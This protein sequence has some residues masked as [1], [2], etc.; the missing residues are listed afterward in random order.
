MVI[1]LAGATMTPNPGGLAV[2]VE[3]LSLTTCRGKLRLRVRPADERVGAVDQHVLDCSPH[4]CLRL[5]RRAV[6]STSTWIWAGQPR[7]G[8]ELEPGRY[9]AMNMY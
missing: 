3:G 1:W 7:R 2:G 6:A 8:V 4:R 9:W 5:L